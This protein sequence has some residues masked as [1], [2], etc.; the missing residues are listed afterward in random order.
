MLATNI[1]QFFL[2]LLGS[3]RIQ[4]RS[5][6]I[7][8]NPLMHRDLLASFTFPPPNAPAEL[9]KWCHGLRQSGG[10]KKVVL[11]VIDNVC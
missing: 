1:G 10:L 3:K 7:S 5:R 2:S 6:F 11:E 9:A 8:L 4:F